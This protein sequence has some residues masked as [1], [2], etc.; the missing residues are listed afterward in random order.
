MSYGLCVNSIP[1]YGF[2]SFRYFEE[3]EKHVNR[4]CTDDVLVMVFD[5]VLKF[6]E[7]GHLVEVGAG[8]YYIQEKGLLQEGIVESESPQYYYIH[9]WG[10]FQEGDRC[11]PLYGKADFTELF[12]LF[13]KLDLQ[14]MTDAPLI[15]R[16]RVFLQILGSL[17]GYEKKED[18]SKVVRA[19]LESVARDLRQPFSL[20]EIGDKIGYCKN[21]II[22]LFKAE[23]GETPYA[24]VT[25]IRLERACELLQHSASSVGQIAVE[26]GFGTYV[27][28]YK[29][30][31]K[32]YHCSPQEWRKSLR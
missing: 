26:C 6:H 1:R 30:F 10:D 13:H 12:P 14:K 23:L 7:D 28:F 15:E 17:L 19:V 4:V 22:A 25:R 29:A 16:E 31:Q 32:Q 20:E 21:Y 9:F 2:S 5:G 11:L 18:H 8:E 3:N 27:N 24:Y